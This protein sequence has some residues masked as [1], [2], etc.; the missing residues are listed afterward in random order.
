MM[1]A[2]QEVP[3]ATTTADLLLDYAR[4]FRARIDLRSVQSK[5]GSTDSKDQRQAVL[6]TVYHLLFSGAVAEANIE[7][8]LARTWDASVPPAVLPE[9]VQTRADG[10]DRW[11]NFLGW[12][13]TRFGDVH[14]IIGAL[15]FSVVVL[16][17]FEG[18]CKVVLTESR[19]G[20]G[21]VGLADVLKCLRKDGWAV[22][23][24]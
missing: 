13:G 9:P 11:A 2:A 23:S 14:N 19:L 20:T 8:Y 22:S 5:L 1:T 4:R 12:K 15:S 6:F 18:F 16:F 17:L 24:T 10:K 21:K 3:M 7:H